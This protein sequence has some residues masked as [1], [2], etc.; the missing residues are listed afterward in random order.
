MGRPRREAGDTE[1]MDGNVEAFVGAADVGVQGSDLA[2]LSANELGLGTQG[3]SFSGN[4]LEAHETIPFGAGSGPRLLDTEAFNF[5]YPEGLASN[6]E[7]SFP[8]WDTP[9]DLGQPFST[10]VDTPLPLQTPPNT[11]DELNSSKNTAGN[12]VIGCSCLSDLCSI[13]A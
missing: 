8:N 2:V 11:S 5:N 13:L 7:Q 9:Q 3:F 4:S 6:L 10:F 1:D 12:A